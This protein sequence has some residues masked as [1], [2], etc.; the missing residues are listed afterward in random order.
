MSKYYKG[1]N[2]FSHGSE[3]CS[4]ILLVNLG[5]P[6]APTKSA[7]RRYLKEFLEDPRVVESPR[8]LW[9]LILNL[10]I[11]NLRPAR[12]AKLYAK[13]WGKDGSPLLA[14]SKRQHLALSE[15]IRQEIP[16]PVH[17]ELAMRYGNPSVAD[18]L[19]K[20]RAANVRRLLILPLYPQY[21][22]TTTAS[23]YD[24]V[25]R[26]LSQWRWVPEL[27]LVNHYCDHS[28]YIHAC[29]TRIQEYWDQH[30]QAQKLLFSFH[31]IPKRYLLAGDP[32][33]CQCHKTARLI[34]ERLELQDDQWQLSFQSRFG[35]EEW[36]KPYTDHVL[37]L[38]PK[39]GIK[40][41]DIF[42]PG[43]AADCLETLEEIQIQN[44]NFFIQAGGEEFD[45]IPALNDMPEHIDALYELIS[46]HMQGW[47]ET[48]SQWNVE[49]QQLAR[50]QSRD[51]ALAHGAKR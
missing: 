33:H 49:D 10:I 22:A 17:I 25:F 47:P 39:Q 21:S 20:L 16:R 9:W 35:R 27:R 24:A 51:R 31:G 6:D 14:I 12:S 23:T 28:G 26:I 50:Q 7:L 5:T 45:Y 37:K 1:L 43:F 29:A 41:V 18:G 8:W 36:L 19:E 46:N 42:C 44:R 2:D 3:E 11:L 40:K 48:S 4:G 13:V 34:A 38:L 32:Y 30:G 15:K